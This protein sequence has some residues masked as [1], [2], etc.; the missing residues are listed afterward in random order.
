MDLASQRSTF[1]ASVTTILHLRLRQSFP[2]ARRIETHVLRVALAVVPSVPLLPS[3]VEKL[4]PFYLRLWL[5]GFAEGFRV[6]HE[7]S[8]S[9]A[10]DKETYASSQL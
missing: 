2:V 7:S 1:L 6:L 5:T 8:A 4:F 9:P 3:A 10:S